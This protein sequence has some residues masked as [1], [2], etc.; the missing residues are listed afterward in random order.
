VKAGRAVTKDATRERLT[1][2]DSSAIRRGGQKAR[3]QSPAGFFPSEQLSVR[4]WDGGDRSWDGYEALHWRDEW[5]RAM[6]VAG[7]P[8]HVNR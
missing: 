2:V 6:D 5:P 7:A 1:I 4:S 8:R 3:R